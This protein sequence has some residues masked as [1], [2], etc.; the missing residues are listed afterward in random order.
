MKIDILL[1]RRIFSNA[2]KYHL[3][4]LATPMAYIWGRGM[5]WV[6][7]DMRRMILISYFYL[8]L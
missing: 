4:I 6:L 3:H 8:M 1:R 2:R 5:W 7:R